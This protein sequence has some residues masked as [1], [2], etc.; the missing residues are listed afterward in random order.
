MAELPAY[1]EDILGRAP[2]AELLKDVSE[3]YR[4]IGGRS[5]LLGLLLEQA[6]ALESATGSKV[7]VGMLHSE[8]RIGAA[9][10]DIRKN[11]HDAVLPLPACPLRGPYEGK[12][13]VSGL[14]LLEP[15]DW[16]AHPL[17]VQAFCEKLGEEGDVVLFTAHHLSKSE[18][19]YESDFQGLASA[20]A[21]QA[22]IGAWRLAYQGTEAK[23]S[24]EELALDGVRSVTLCPLGYLADCLETLYDCDVLLRSM[25]EKLGLGFSRTPTPDPIPCWADVVR[26]GLSA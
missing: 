25:C 20:V 12:V 14:R 10:E 18:Q 15:P 26:K 16:H 9:V 1:L 22:G 6:Q 19:R 17:L 4:L 21:A 23:R 13:K 3:R 2:S 7:Y 11:G 5:P 24:L 8:P